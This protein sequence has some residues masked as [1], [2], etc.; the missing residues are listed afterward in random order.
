MPGVGGKW[1]EVME[2][3]E[4]A[5]RRA[6]ERRARVVRSAVCLLVRLCAGLENAVCLMRMR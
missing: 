6:W 4:R 5:R 3:M 2:W 1:L